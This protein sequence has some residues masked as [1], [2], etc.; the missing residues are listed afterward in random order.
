MG[1]ETNAFWKTLKVSKLY[2]VFSSFRAFVIYFFWF[3]ATGGSGLGDI[4][5]RISVTFAPKLR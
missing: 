4:L 1:L 5:A 2:F 3:S